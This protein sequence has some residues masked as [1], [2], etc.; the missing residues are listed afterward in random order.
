MTLSEWLPCKGIVDARGRHGGNEITYPQMGHRQEP[1]SHASVRKEWASKF[2]GCWHS[3]P[4][5]GTWISLRVI[6]HVR[7]VEWVTI[8]RA[9]LALFPVGEVDRERL[10]RSRLE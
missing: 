3:R 4:L 9:S 6:G 7:L 10:S 8:W 5:T 1:V 2:C